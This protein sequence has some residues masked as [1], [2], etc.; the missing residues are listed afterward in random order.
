MSARNRPV[1]PGLVIVRTS[2]DWA[3]AVPADEVPEVLRALSWPR[4]D[5]GW[6]D[7]R[8][9][10]WPSERKDRPTLTLCDALVPPP[11]PKSEGSDE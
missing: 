3:I 1:T 9:Q 6:K 8:E 4:V 11:P 7:G 2:W 10:H 5:S